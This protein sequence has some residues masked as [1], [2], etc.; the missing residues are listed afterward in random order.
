M[1]AV[2]E[3]DMDRLSAWERVI[4]R[5]VHGPGVQQGIWR[6]KT[7]WEDLDIVA[8]IGMDWTCS[9]NGSGKDSGENI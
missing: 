7:D 1:W 5:R 9:K 4:L 6:V 2:A 8:D 3:V